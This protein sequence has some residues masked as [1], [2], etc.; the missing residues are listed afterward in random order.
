MKRIAIP[1]MKITKDCQVYGYLFGVMI[2]LCLD[3]N[4]KWTITKRSRK[5][6]H[7]ARNGQKLR[8]THCAF[9]RLFEEV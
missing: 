7:L 9:D 8:L 6:Y 1:K 2:T 4:Q 3:T 5:Y